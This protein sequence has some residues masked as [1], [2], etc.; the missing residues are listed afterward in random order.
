MQPLEH[1]TRTSGQAFDENVLAKQRA[2]IRCDLRRSAQRSDE[3][4]PCVRRAGRQRLI[5]RRG[6]D[7]L[8]DDI[9]T[10]AAG[11]LDDSGAPLRMRAVV[12]GDIGTERSRR[13]ELLIARRGDRNARTGHLGNLHGHHRKSASAERQHDLA[14]LHC[15]ESMNDRPCRHADRGHRRSILV[16]DCV[17]Q[18]HQGICRQQHFLSEPSIT[19]IAEIRSEYAGLELAIDPGGERHGRHAIAHFDARY[20]L[21]DRDDIAGAVRQRDPISRLQSQI[22]S[23]ENRK[24]AMIQSGRAHLDHHLARSGHGLGTLH[25]RKRIE[26]FLI[27]DLIGVDLAATR[28]PTLRGSRQTHHRQTRHAGRHGAYCI[29]SRDFAHH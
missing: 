2:E 4:D 5:Q 29:S 20:A 21:A 15:T 28:A 7:R 10:A 17:R 23:V 16:A 24:I 6:T 26:T 12:D 14:R 9:R 19:T 3:T 27:A 1:A 8:H 22:T 13:F 18:L 11:R 25:S